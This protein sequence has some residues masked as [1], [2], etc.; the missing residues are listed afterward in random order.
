[1]PKSKKQTTGGYEV[2]AVA[3]PASRGIEK[4]GKTAINNGII[5]LPKEQMKA[6]SFPGQ[7]HSIRNS[8]PGGAGPQVL[9]KARPKQA[10][11]KSKFP[12]R[13]G[14]RLD[15]PPRGIDEV[16]QEHDEL[17]SALNASAEDPEQQQVQFAINE[18]LREEEA[19]KQQVKAH[20][21][22]LSR[23][24]AK[25]KRLED[26]INL[27]KKRLSE[28]SSHNTHIQER[29]VALTKERRQLQE[30]SRMMEKERIKLDAACNERRKLELEIQRLRQKQHNLPSNMSEFDQLTA[31]SHITYQIEDTSRTLR[32]VDEECVKLESVKHAFLE[33]DAQMFNIGAENTKLEKEFISEEII[34]QST[35]EIEKTIDKLKEDLKQ[36]REQGI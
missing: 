8:P 1:M 22:A 28:L 11:V 36:L 29:R 5:K 25:T 13:G 27:N 24:N 3:G 31:L 9:P 17:M 26:E 7:G 4:K 35:Q 23:Y 10:R 34:N 32:A 2:R 30:Q 14:L 6:P 33:I 20:A 18:S 12:R 15:V 19:R 21:H 16:S